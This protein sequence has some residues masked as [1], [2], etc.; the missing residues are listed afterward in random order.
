[1]PARASIDAPST[2]QPDRT[3]TMDVLVGPGGVSEHAPTIRARRSQLR[4]PVIDDARR[5]TV[6][7][8]RDLTGHGPR[9]SGCV[10][11]AREFPRL[12]T[13]AIPPAINFTNWAGKS[14]DSARSVLA[15]GGHWFSGSN[16]RPASAIDPQRSLPITNASGAEL[17]I[18]D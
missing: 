9:V 15:L 4:R 10:I 13:A 14:S 17:C 7:D 18:A 1:M 16:A 8:D 5:Q 6:A 12:R 2:R 3:A 11:T